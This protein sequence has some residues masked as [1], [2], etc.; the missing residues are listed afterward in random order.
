MHVGRS[1]TPEKSQRSRSVSSTG[2]R[3]RVRGRSPAFNAL[4][5]KFEN[6][7][8]RNLSTPPAMVQKNHP[9]AGSPSPDSTK[10]PMTTLVKSSTIAAITSSFE[11]SPIIAARDLLIPRSQKYKID[12]SKYLLR[13]LVLMNFIPAV[14]SPSITIEIISSTR[15]IGNYISL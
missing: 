10:K 5:A 2:D 14:F 12:K 15:K 6:P 1:N 11:K 7:N 9:K 3:P 8:A 13:I 4:A